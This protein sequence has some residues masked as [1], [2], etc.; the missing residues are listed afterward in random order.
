MRFFLLII[1][2]F[3][4]SIT[5][6][7]PTLPSGC[8]PIAVQGDSV[9][10]KAQKAKLI[11]IHNLSQLDLWI[12]HPVSNPSAS[13]GWASRLQQD[14]WSA[15]AVDKPKFDITC[16]ESRPGHEQ[17]VPCEGVLAVCEWKGVKLPKKDSG[18]FWV[19]ED[20]PL[21]ELKAAIGGRG[22][23]LPVAK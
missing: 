18:T 12:T 11:F 14:H 5:I 2:G 21:A 16:I 23:V 19:G 6:A 3:V 7:E 10:I 17:Q 15:L 4:S 13:A 8:Q 9:T 20:L 22:Y 1:L